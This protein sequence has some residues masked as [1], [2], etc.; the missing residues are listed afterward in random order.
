M[1]HDLLHGF[2]PGSGICPPRRPIDRTSPKLVFF[3]EPWMV[4]GSMGGR[5]YQKLRRKCEAK[6]HQHQHPDI[7]EDL[8][9][10]GRTMFAPILRLGSNGVAI[11]G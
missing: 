4:G 3:R 9:R 2:R 11:L 7:C 1:N 5:S 10:V 8:R 6:R